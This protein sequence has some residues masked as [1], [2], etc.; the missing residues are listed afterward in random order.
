MLASHGR[1]PSQLY[2]CQFFFYSAVLEHFDGLALVDDE[3]LFV[4]NLPAGVRVWV[5]INQI[6]GLVF[7]EFQTI[8]EK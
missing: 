5:I 6:F 3:I 2:K 8:W 4:K 7:R 1:D